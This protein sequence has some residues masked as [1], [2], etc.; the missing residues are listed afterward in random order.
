MDAE[1]EAGLDAVYAYCNIYTPRSAANYIKTS[2]ENGVPAVT[3]F[4]T[5]WDNRYW[6][7]NGGYFIINNSPSKFEHCFSCVENEKQAEHPAGGLKDMILL[8]NWSEYGEG[9][10][11]LP[12][13]LYGFGYLAAV[14]RAVTGDRGYHMDVRPEGPFNSWCINP[15]VYGDGIEGREV[16]AEFPADWTVL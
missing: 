11:I 6:V 15:T 12:S 13:A 4:G 2:A 14:R 10:S 3:S 8:D 9:H 1:K 7:D 5:G 16:V